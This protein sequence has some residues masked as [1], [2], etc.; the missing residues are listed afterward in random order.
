MPV[1]LRP[2]DAEAVRDC[3]VLSAGGAI[4]IVRPEAA[5]DAPA[6]DRFR[7]HADLPDAPEKPLGST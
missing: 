1:R 3:A 2:S 6:R 5:D 7:L 4:V